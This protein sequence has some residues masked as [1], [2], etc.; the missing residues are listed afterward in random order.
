MHGSPILT[1]QTTSDIFLRKEGITSIFKSGE[2]VATKQIIG[3]YK[4]IK[5]F[6]TLK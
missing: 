1:L 6:M 3:L 4:D 5:K 2:I